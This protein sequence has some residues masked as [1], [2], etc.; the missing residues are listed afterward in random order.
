[1]LTDLYVLDKRTGMIHR[2]GNDCHDSLTIMDGEVHYH[3]M[4]NGD[5]G[6]CSN[7]EGYGYVILKSEFG[8]L[9]DEYGIIDKRFEKKIRRY[10]K[11]E[12]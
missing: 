8:M 10:L 4:Q 3:N 2:I 7:V 12:G 1:M 11:E 9:E 5:G 6:T